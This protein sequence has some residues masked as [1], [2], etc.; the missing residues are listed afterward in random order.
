MIVPRLH[1][2]EG[3]EGEGALNLTNVILEDP[4]R[5]ERERCIGMVNEMDEID[6]ISPQK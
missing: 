5:T 2:G 4:L 6:S 3:P 1:I